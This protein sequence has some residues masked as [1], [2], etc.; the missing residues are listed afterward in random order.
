MNGSVGCVKVIQAFTYSMLKVSLLGSIMVPN[1]VLDVS[2]R[3]SLET[4]PFC[5]SRWP[6]LL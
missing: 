1:F 3:L 4:P 5:E 6:N 2:R